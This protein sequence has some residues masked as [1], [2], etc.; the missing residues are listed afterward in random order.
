MGAHYTTPQIKQS[1]LEVL[2][3]AGETQERV[4]VGSDQ[5]FEWLSNNTHFHLQNNAG[6]FTA[7]KEKRRNTYYW[8]AYRKINGKL[9]KKYLGAS[10]QL[11]NKRFYETA[12]A[13]G[14]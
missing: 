13:L 8:Y 6:S 3:N 11:T 2:T 5:W 12:E 14:L 10:N 9:K 1:I 4:T 7:R